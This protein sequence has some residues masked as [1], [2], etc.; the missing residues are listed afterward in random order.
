MENNN[1]GELYHLLETM[2]QE[3]R[4]EEKITE[5]RNLINEGE[6]I[7]A[8]EKV[9]ELQQES[10]LNNKKKSNNR[11]KNKNKKEIED[12][13][14]D[15]KTYEEE[16]SE[17]KDDEAYKEGNE[18][19]ID[20]E[21]NEE[22]KEEI[23]EEYNEEDKEEIDNEYDE[24]E[25]KE[26]IDNEYDEE[27]SEESQ[28]EKV[29]KDS[30]RQ[31]KGKYPEILQNDKL[32]RM[33]LGL[34]LNNPKLIQKYYIIK[35]DC[36]FEEDIY[37]NIYKSVLFTEGADYTP[38]IAKNGYNF[39]QISSELYSLKEEL[40]EETMN[41]NDKIE[42]I[43]VEIRKLFKIRRAYVEQPLR[44]LQE[45]IL[46]IVNYELYDKMSLE[47]VNGAITQVTVTQKFKS[48]ILN[49]GLTRFLEEGNNNLTNG[50]EAPFPILSS[51]F[52][53]F[54]KGETTAFAMPSNTGKSRFTT[55][56][57]AYFAFVHK[58]KVLIISNEMSEDK[59]KLCFITTVLN[60]PAIQK[61]Y[62]HKLN[63]TETE[64]LEFKFRP[65]KSQKVEVDKDGYVLQ[66]ENES[67]AEFVERLEKVSSE[68]R[69]VIR[70]TN[71]AEKQ[72]EDAIYFI[73]IPDHTNDELQKVIMNYYYKEKIE[74][75]FY[76]TLKTD[77]VNIGKDVEIKKTA[78]ILSNLA[79]GFQI[80]IFS[81]LQLLEN[82]TPPLELTIND[83]AVS[84][85]VKEVL[86][87]LTLIKQIPKNELKNYEY[88]KEELDE[89][90][91]QIKIENDPD[92][93]YY[94]CVI[95]KNRAGAKPKLLFKVN[96]AYNSW[97]ELG[98]LRVKTKNEK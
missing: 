92:I 6:Y 57:A 85:T 32:E 89:K 23:D 39:A 75:M 13:K 61:I 65:D 50:L 27:D 18:E 26:E 91:F 24:E 55:Y 66:K 52:K 74:Y 2:R 71:W 19:E 33:Y 86:D 34:L 54:R 1:L 44:E 38:E 67:R 10:N 88:T 72:M 8:L 76:D 16:T 7:E 82:S 41:K 90:A 79:Q 70:I 51:V 30:K 49:I 37:L 42:K 87:T 59:M 69:E 97:E 21:Y 95:D 9:K 3:G 83:L 46:E 11:K 98:Y 12:K 77:T 29:R 15:L 28:I 40:K 58:K 47:E 84:R 68:Y 93:R 17:I 63:I 53:G 31:I 62:G 25:D 78:T 73:Y 80:F 56:L 4:N 43:Y 81:T 5:I 35:E 22:D 14:T 45:K 60:C 48:S 36:F 94:A 20:E 64:L 96:L